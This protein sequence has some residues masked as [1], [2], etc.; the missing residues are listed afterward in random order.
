MSKATDDKLKNLGD[1]LSMEIKGLSIAMDARFTIMDA[2]F[3]ISNAK[4][5]SKLDALRIELKGREARFWARA[6][7][8]VSGLLCICY[9]LPSNNVKV[10]AVAGLT[11]S[12]A[13][14]QYQN[15]AIQTPTTQTPDSRGPGS[16]GRTEMKQ[17]RGG[18]SLSGDSANSHTVLYK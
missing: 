18:P 12:A 9:I 13:F 10:L 3:E 11:S 6:I 2:R 8:T 7:F 15:R 5:Q 1:K 14:L 4:T 17:V 16:C